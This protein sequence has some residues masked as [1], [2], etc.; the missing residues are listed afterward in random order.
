M[1]FLEVRNNSGANANN[2]EYKEIGAPINIRGR[3]FLYIMY[4]LSR[5]F[6]RL[7]HLVDAN[8]DKSE[9]IY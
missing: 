9:T 7:F 1:R 6:P 4:L 3:I 2:A 8:F 5:V